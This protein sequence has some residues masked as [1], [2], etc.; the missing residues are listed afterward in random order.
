MFG[1]C[2]QELKKKEK[3]MNSLNHMNHKYSSCSSHIYTRKTHELLLKENKI[4]KERLFYF[5]LFPLN[6][7]LANAKK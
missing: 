4:K 2:N 6:E 1:D 7:C 3:K 5:F